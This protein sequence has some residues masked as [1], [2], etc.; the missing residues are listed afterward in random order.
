MTYVLDGIKTEM[1]VVEKTIHSPVSRHD[2]Y[3]YRGARCPCGNA[4]RLP[5]DSTQE[6]DSLRFHYT[7]CPKARGEET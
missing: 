2:D 1:V 4:W 7:H 6:T 5:G 3:I